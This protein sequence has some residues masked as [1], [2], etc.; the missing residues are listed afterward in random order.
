M[1]QKGR[2]RYGDELSGLGKKKAG[3]GGRS[4]DGAAQNQGAESRSGADREASLGSADH[5]RRFIFGSLP[6]KRNYAGENGG[7]PTGTAG[8][9][10]G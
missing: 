1:L 9:A 10:A 5:M 2:R 8:D 3:A 4:P 7:I 6:G